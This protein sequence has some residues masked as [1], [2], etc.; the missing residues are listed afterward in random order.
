MPAAACQDPADW[1]AGVSE[2]GKKRSGEVATRNAEPQAVWH[3]G[4]MP[5]QTDFSVV[6]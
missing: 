3:R 1:A 2:A 5:K 4:E 6:A